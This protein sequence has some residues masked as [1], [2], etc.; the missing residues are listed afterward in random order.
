MDGLVNLIDWTNEPLRSELQG[1]YI[2]WI[3]LSSLT[4]EMLW[5]CGF[6]LEMFHEQLDYVKH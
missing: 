4:S 5:S 1:L 2:T 6:E 3:M